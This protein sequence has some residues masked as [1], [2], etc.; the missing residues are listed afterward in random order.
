MSVSIQLACGYTAVNQ[1]NY[2]DAMVCPQTDAYDGIGRYDP[3][4]ATG[5][6]KVI[7]FHVSPARECNELYSL[8]PR[9]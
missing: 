5:D 2:M 1:H 3:S 9:S 6:Y 4:L 7:S 8:L